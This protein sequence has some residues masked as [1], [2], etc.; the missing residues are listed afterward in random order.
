MEEEPWGR[1]YRE[2]TQWSEAYGSYP[3]TDTVCTYRGL[4]EIGEEVHARWK[5]GHRETSEHSLNRED[6]L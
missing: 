2:Y 5:R 6:D 3:I 1:E 4:E